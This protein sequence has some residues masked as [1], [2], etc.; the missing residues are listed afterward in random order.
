[1]G[2]SPADDCFFPSICYNVRG[3][4][5]H[6]MSRIWVRLIKRHRIAVQDTMPC[7]RGGEKDA[8]I[9]LC[10]EMDV[11]APMWLPKNEREYEQFRQT[12][13]THDNF[14]E[15]LG[16]DR[17]EI[18]FLDDTERSHKSGDPRNAFDSM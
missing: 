9:E 17:M 4:G 6:T 18:E 11:P 13:F 16:Y 2:V 12:S 3:K 8:L 14:V 7:P 5:G 1:M 15:S 10:R